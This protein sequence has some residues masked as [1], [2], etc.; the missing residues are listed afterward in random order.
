MTERRSATLK[1][2]KHGVSAAPAVLICIVLAVILI[3]FD[4]WGSP[5]SNPS[6]PIS[7]FSQARFRS[8]VVIT[9]ASH[10]RGPGFET[11]RNLLAILFDAAGSVDE[12]CSNN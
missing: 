11:R 5:D 12:I 10:A 9:L 1:K 8:V 2:E 4:R 7:E 3:T 6:I